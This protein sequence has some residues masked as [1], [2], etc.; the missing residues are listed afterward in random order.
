MDRDRDERR[1]RPRELKL[2]FEL[3]KCS[4]L[5]RAWRIS[6]HDALEAEPA[7]CCNQIQRT[8]EQYTS[9]R[10]PEE[11]CE[12]TCGPGNGQSA[13]QH[14]LFTHPIAQTRGDRIAHHGD[15]R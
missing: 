13:G 8:C 3:R 7:D 6:L 14:R 1:T 12:D 5:V 4:A 15:E 10:T 11:R 2:G 9:D